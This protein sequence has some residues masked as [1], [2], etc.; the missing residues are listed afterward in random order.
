MPGLFGVVFYLLLRCGTGSTADL[1]GV[2]I[3]GLRLVFWWLCLNL[4]RGRV[5]W[6]GV[7]ADTGVLIVWDAPHGKYRRNG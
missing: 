2:A 7:T 1:Y 3:G 5:V 4:N 6:E